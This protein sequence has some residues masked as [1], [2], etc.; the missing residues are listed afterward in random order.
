M[1]LQLE[2]NLVDDGRKFLNFWDWKHGNDVCC[3]IIGGVLFKS[4]RDNEGNELPKTVLL[5]SDFIT[6]V[7]QS[8][9]EH[10]K[11]N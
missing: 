6:L 7:E 9:S 1:K 3:E 4:E 8:V 11:T 5:L 10:N 2:L